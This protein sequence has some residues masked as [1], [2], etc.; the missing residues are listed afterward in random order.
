MLDYVIIEA[1]RLPQNKMV[2]TKRI[3]RNQRISV[4]RTDS[5]DL[6]VNDDPEISSLHFLVAVGDDVCTITD[7][8]STNKTYYNDKP[9]TQINIG[10]G[11]RILCGKTEFIFRLVSTFDNQSSIN[12]FINDLGRPETSSTATPFPASKADPTHPVERSTEVKRVPSPKP[13]PTSPSR[14][15]QPA[16]PVPPVFS[17]SDQPVPA[18]PTDSEE[19][20]NWS[21]FSD[22]ESVTGQAGKAQITGSEGSHP[23]GTERR[24]PDQPSVDGF[25]A[26]ND[27]LEF[28]ETR[29]IS[30]QLPVGN[31]VQVAIRI[32]GQS[33]PSARLVIDPRQN[34]KAVIGRA[35]SSHLPCPSDT[36]MSNRHF[37]IEIQDNQCLIRDLKSRNGT[38]VNGQRI[39]IALLHHGDRVCA[40]Q[41]DFEIAIEVMR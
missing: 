30:G 18:T 7:Q 1:R 24:L 34:S 14:H 16:I 20:I 13:I 21:T 11:E 15:S 22:E 3:A 29:V 10:D 9:I 19:V 8:N 39:V 26:G 25:V 37:E 23:L 6:V 12:P 31:I 38:S 17:P 32:A 4:G 27:A 28:E 40:G 36:S 41:T 35:A 33:D 2:L 5:A